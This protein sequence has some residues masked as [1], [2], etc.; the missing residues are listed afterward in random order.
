MLEIIAAALLFLVQPPAQLRAEEKPVTVG[1]ISGGAVGAFPG[2]RSSDPAEKF[3]VRKKV[4]GRAIFDV[5]SAELKDVRVDNNF[6]Q[7]TLVVHIYLNEN[8]CPSLPENLAYTLRRI[9]G[10]G[11]DGI[12]SERYEVELVNLMSGKG[13]SCPMYRKSVKGALHLPLLER[14]GEENRTVTFAFK[15]KSF[16]DTDFAK[17]VTVRLGKD[18]K[19]SVSVK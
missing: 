8:Q 9:Q 17:D 18:K 1:F 4:V 19:Y 14:T 16:S 3:I 13:G 15:G 2:S 12:G 10:G 11:N 5:S 7:A 6:F